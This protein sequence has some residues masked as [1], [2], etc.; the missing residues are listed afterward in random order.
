MSVFF[1]FHATPLNRKCKKKKFIRILALNR[2]QNAHNLHNERPFS[3]PLR[4]NQR[5]PRP[6][7]GAAWV[8]PEAKLAAHYDGVEL[9]AVAVVEQ[10]D[11]ASNMHR[12]AIPASMTSPAP[13][14]GLRLR[15]ARSH[16][17]SSHQ[18][19]PPPPYS[20]TLYA[21]DTPLAPPLAQAARPLR[22]RVLRALTDHPVLHLGRVS[23]IAAAKQSQHPIPHARPTLLLPR[24]PIHPH[25]Q[26]RIH[27][28]H[29][30]RNLFFLASGPH[31]YRV[32]GPQVLVPSPR[33]PRKPHSLEVHHARLPQVPVAGS[34]TVRACATS[35]PEC[36][37][38]EGAA[39]P[40]GMRADMHCA[41]L[42][43]ALGG[44]SVVARTERGPCPPLHDL[45]E[46]RDAA[47]IVPVHRGCARM[48]RA[49]TRTRGQQVGYEASA[50]WPARSPSRSRGGRRGGGW[51]AGTKKG[52]QHLAL[53]RG[54]K[55]E[56]QRGAGGA[57]SARD[58]A[59]DAVEAVS[60]ARVGTHRLPVLTG[61]RRVRRADRMQVQGAARRGRYG[62]RARRR[63]RAGRYRVPVL[64]GMRRGIS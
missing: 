32:H 8:D 58:G 1:P 26:R 11:V 6:F 19:I 3:H 33:P 48:M 36:A 9:T 24:S 17:P 25:I 22:L 49:T 56:G 28:P 63:A 62:E 44:V 51:G 7:G 59:A 55:S 31:L 41:A 4:F 37:R 2:L 38:V 12:H 61:I 43:R 16:I 14:R 40:R 18:L 21:F 27:F 5:P 15:L 46:R 35:L 20:P 42:S 53:T 30:P 52:A 29:Q 47:R 60:D 50:P 39:A 34:H 10:V 45:H 54:C 13:C 64:A 57:G 23:V